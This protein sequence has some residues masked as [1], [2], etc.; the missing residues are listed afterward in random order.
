MK[1]KLARRVLGTWAVALLGLFAPIT[2]Q[3]SEWGW[4]QEEWYDPTDWF[5]DSNWEYDQYDEDEI[6]FGQ[7]GDWED[8]FGFEDENT[9][10]DDWNESFDEGRRYD[11]YGY[12]DRGFDEGYD[13]DFGWN[14]SG[15]SWNEYEY[16]TSEW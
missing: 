13:G 14:E 12:T 11:E 7:E 16:F 8:S 5:N 9:W 15:W 10:G 6:D 1:Q 2:A 4:N 3:E